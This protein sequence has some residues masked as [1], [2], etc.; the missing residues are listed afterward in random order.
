MCTGKRNSC[1]NT[2]TSGS[3]NTSNMTL[4]IYMLAI[5]PQNRSGCSWS[6][7]GPGLKPHNTSAAH[8]IGRAYMAAT[9]QKGNSA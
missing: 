5:S 1:A 9:T 4:P 2:G 3:F 6:S 7:S 8:V